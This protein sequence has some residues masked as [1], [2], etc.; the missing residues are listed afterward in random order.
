MSTASGAWRVPVRM[1]DALASWRWPGFEGVEPGVRVR[2][3]GGGPDT[4]RVWL[5]EAEQA[6]SRVDLATEAAIE[7]AWQARRAANRRLFDAAII[8]CHG[9]EP[10]GHR[11]GELM[12]R[13]ESYRR[14]S[15]QPEL[16]LGVVSLGVTG[17]V[18]GRDAAG[19][20]RLC[21]AQRGAGTRCYPGLWEL[22]PCGGVDA[23]EVDGADGVKPLGSE[24][25]ERQLLFELEEELGGLAG[26]SVSG[27]VAL[28]IDEGP[29]SVDVVMRVAVSDG[30]IDAMGR[31]GREGEG[32]WE[33]ERV[34]WLAREE[35]EGWLGLMGGAVKPSTRGLL[36]M[37]ASGGALGERVWGVGV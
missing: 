19:V 35:I 29:P 13:P 28:V 4:V 27:L 18:I 23:G 2:V 30:V 22:A 9:F 1:A 11:G 31:D 20:E 16:D 8:A 37:M 15:V 3:V 7:R 12:A 14:L 5:V 6:A 34:A 17:V 24:A 33:Y 36:R 25:L 32:A 26:A 21:V 10:D